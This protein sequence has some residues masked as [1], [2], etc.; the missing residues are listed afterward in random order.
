MKDYGLAK[1]E[2]NI[3]LEELIRNIKR[4]RNWNSGQREIRLEEA[5]SKI[6]EKVSE[7]KNLVSRLCYN[8]Q[9]CKNAGID[10][11]NIQTEDS[12]LIKAAIADYLLDQ[13]S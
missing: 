9:F 1:I 12:R 4:L 6:P 10:Y 2:F 13:E 3:S 5:D 7:A 8:G 11:D